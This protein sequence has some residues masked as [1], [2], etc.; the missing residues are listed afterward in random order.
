MCVGRY[1]KT[2][3]N[4]TKCIIKRGPFGISDG[5]KVTMPRENHLIS[6]RSGRNHNFIRS[7]LTADRSRRVRRKKFELDK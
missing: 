3:R 2:M 6:A 1:A 5:L 7:P 4:R